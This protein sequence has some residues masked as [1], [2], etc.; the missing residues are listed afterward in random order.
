LKKIKV[1]PPPKH[2]SNDEENLGQLSSPKA[3]STL[4]TVE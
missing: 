2:P 1:D 4:T 3:P